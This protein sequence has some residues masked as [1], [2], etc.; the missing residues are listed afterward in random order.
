MVFHC[1]EASV[2][3]IGAGCLFSQSV[4]FRPSDAHKIFDLTTNTRI[5]APVPIRIGASVW[6]GQEVLFLKGANV[7][8]GCIVGA[9]SLVNKSFDEENCILAGVPAKIVRRQVRW[10]P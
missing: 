1:H 10:A 2:V 3:E 9:R 5:N 8:A 4:Q 7:P 6:V